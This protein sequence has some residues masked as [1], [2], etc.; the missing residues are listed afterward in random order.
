MEGP[1]HKRSLNML[2]CELED[3]FH[4]LGTDGP[5]PREQWSGLSLRAETSVRRMLDLFAD[6]GVK[7]TF[8]CLG[9]MAERMPALVR[10]C[11]RAGHEIGSHGYGHV[12]AYDVGPKA[13][14]KDLERAKKVLEDIIGERVCGFRC[15]GFSVTNGNRWVFDVVAETGHTYDASVFPAHHGHGG[16]QGT[17]VGPHIV[18]TASGPLVEFPVSTV[19]FLDRR[20]C[21]FGGGYLRLF[22]LRAIRWG[23]RRLHE[24]GLP[25]IV[26]IHPREIDPDHPRLPLTLRRRFKCYVNLH[27]TMRKLTWLCGHYA[28]T[29]MGE[30]AEG[31]RPMEQGQE[32]IVP[33]RVGAEEAAAINLVSIRRPVPQGASAVDARQSSVR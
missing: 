15:P 3:W 23:I 1:N 31:M 4:I 22:P 27:T 6:H 25:L 21:M 16:F 19:P 5:P 14:K 12:L 26:Y 28:F 8:F 2:T 17:P 18:E 9:W 33:A 24:D 10:D 7:A 13:F 20:I 30:V 29:Q 11:R 32:E